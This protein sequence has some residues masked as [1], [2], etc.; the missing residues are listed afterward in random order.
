[1]GPLETMSI[2][3]QPRVDPEKPLLIVDVDEVLAL[4]VHGF[5]RFI[6]PQGYEMRID[7]FALFQN[8]YRRGESEHLDLV[9]GRS[10][11]DDFF[12]FGVEDIEPAPEAARSLRQLARAGVGIVALTN[13][14]AQ[15][16]EPRMRW[17][18]RHAMNYPLIINEG[19]KGPAVAGLAALTHKPVAFVDDML[20]N[21]D[22]VADAA[23]RVRRFQLVADLRLQPLAPTEPDRHCRIDHWPQLR[24]ALAT[25]LGVAIS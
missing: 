3:D 23:P 14:P 22:S 20:I 17:L 4:F 19:P 2:A 11:H 13:A 21:L 10:L 24:G 7:R 5:A 15:A 1:M 25:A 9:T 6:E 16:R 8:I 12:R 18:R